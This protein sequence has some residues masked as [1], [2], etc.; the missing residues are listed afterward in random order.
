MVVLCSNITGVCSW[1]FNWQ[2][3]SIGS[4]NGLA[5]NKLNIIWTDGGKFYWR[6]Q[7]SLGLDEL[8]RYRR[9]S[10]HCTE[11]ILGAMNFAANIRRYGRGWGWEL[12]V[13]PIR[14]G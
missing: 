13:K 4:D 5:P 9:F 2:Y 10:P 1:G 6:I 12:G 14:R 3:A 8:K 11:F 7:A